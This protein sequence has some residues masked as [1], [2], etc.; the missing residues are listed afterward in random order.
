MI[1]LRRALSFAA[2]SLA[3]RAAAPQCV[4]STFAGGSAAGATDGV[5]T[6]SA[7][8]T[9]S[10]L[11][12]DAAGFLLLADR[13]NNVVRRISASAT[14]ST[15]LGSGV[16]AS[17]DGL[18][19]AAQLNA[20]AGVAQDVAGNVYITEAGGHRVRVATPAGALTTLAGSGA[21][22]FSD[23][24]GTAAS[25]NAPRGVAATTGLIVVADTGNNRIRAI[26]PAGVVTTLSGSG[27]AAFVDAWGPL[28]AFSGPIGV[29]FDAFGNVIVADAG[30][31]RV[32]AVAQSGLTATLAGG[33][34]A[35]DDDGAGIAALF[36]TPADVAVD[37]LGNVLVVDGANFNVRAI[38]PAGFVTTLA[39]A[40]VA[41]YADG[42]GGAFLQPRDV[43]VTPSGAVIVSDGNAL[44]AVTCAA[45]SVSP[46]PS[47]G[48]AASASGSPTPTP[49][50]TPTPSPTGVPCFV[51]TFAGSR[52]GVA[53]Y[54]DGIGTNALFKT[55]F[56]VA[57]DPLSGIVYVADHSNHRIRAVSPSGSVSL[58]AGSGTATFA[59][60][61][62][63][64]RN[65]RN[66]LTRA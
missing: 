36:S 33:K 42:V 59:V 22:T 25:F 55:P 6:S 49:T 8:S 16:A 14:S 34:T 46:T 24:A 17:V 35:G 15:W 23:G 61:D 64:Y 21:A 13:G 45:A 44:R 48:A 7:F 19:L 38:T 31:N 57:A 28:A 27:A 40:S 41:L 50:G 20:P 1:V 63:R 54:A 47:Q 26:T 5:G 66:T 43:A 32:R 4:V 56:A 30:N 11:C 65:S 52:T 10:G 58:V 9:P 29:A 51:S 53:G 12:A 62:A 18:L 37:G 3:V 39:G 60:S 2:L